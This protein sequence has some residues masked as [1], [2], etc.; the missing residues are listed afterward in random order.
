MNNT[1]QNFNQETINTTEEN[2]ETPTYAQQLFDTPFKTQSLT[3]GVYEATLLEIQPSESD[4]HAYYI[5]IQGRRYAAHKAF[6][7]LVSLQKQ[8]QVIVQVL[9]TGKMVITSVITRPDNQSISIEVDQDF[10]IHTSGSLNFSSQENLNLYSSEKLFCHSQSAMHK[11]DEAWIAYDKT[12]VV[13][14]QLDSTI[15]RIHSVSQWINSLAKQ[16]V[17]QFQGYIR[18]TEGMDQ[19]K[20]GNKKQQVEGLYRVDTDTT[21]MVSQHDTK[22]DG[23]HIH[24]G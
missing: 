4:H 11:S 20:A 2:S 3:P 1:A 12:K 16:V 22:I 10:S 23:Q 13:M 17:Q 7:C 24:M 9:N 19:T 6:S 21:L 8:D 15:E 5:S 14:N 18:Q